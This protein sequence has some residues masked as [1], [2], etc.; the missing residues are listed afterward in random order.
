MK[1]NMFPDF[2]IWYFAS[3]FF[4]KTFYIIVNFMTGVELSS[5]NQHS[6]VI[7][8]VI[9]CSYN[10]FQAYTISKTYTCFLSIS[11][12]F[13]QEHIRWSLFSESIEWIQSTH[14]ISIL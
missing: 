10:I 1:F 9:E 6:L 4:Y 3:I 5:I 14:P 2:C 11:H 13:A 8:F 12:I 7:Q